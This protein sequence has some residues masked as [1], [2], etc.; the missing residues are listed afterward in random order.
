MLKTLIKERQLFKLYKE[1]M[2]GNWKRRGFVIHLNYEETMMQ[3]QMGKK[4]SNLKAIIK[5]YILKAV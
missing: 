3:T 4:P 2:K 1:Q 5:K